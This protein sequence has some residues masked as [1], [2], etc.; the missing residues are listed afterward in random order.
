MSLGAVLSHHLKQFRSPVAVDISEK[1]YVDNLYS[2]VD[3]EADTLSYFH[4]ARELMQQGNFE[5]RQW[6][7]NSRLPFN[8]VREKNTGTH[9]S[10]VSILG[11]SWDTH[12]DEIS[13]PVQNFNSR[14]TELTKRKAISMSRK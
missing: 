10:T 12:K 2:G 9:S 7:I 11:L 3:N 5:L 6:C 8:L 14:D 13:F 1:L 4:E